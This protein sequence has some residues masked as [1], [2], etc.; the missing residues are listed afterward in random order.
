MGDFEI[1]EGDLWGRIGVLRLR[2]GTLETPALLPVVHPFRQELPPGELKALGFG[3]LMTNAYIIYRRMGTPPPGGVHGLLAF[4]GILA[5]DSGGYQALR[6]GSV[7]V[8]PEDMAS[9]QAALGSDIAVILDTPTRATWGRAKAEESVRL[10]LEAA[11][12][13]ARYLDAGPLWVGAIQGGRHLDLVRA[14]SKALV[15]MGFRMLALGGPVEVMEGYDFVTLLRMMAEARR[16]VPPSIPLHLFGAGLPLTIPLAV[17]LG[18]DTF[19]SASYLL[20]AK[21]GRYMTQQG[22]LRL[23]KVSYLPCAC[24]VC[25]SFSPE[26]LRRDV[27]SLA[28]HN[29]YV[30]ASCIREVKESIHEGRLWEL[31][32]TRARAHPQLWEAAKLLARLSPRF[33]LD[34]PM[35]KPR[36]LFFVAPPDQHRPEVLRYR[37][38]LLRHYTPPSTERLVLVPPPSDR[39]LLRSR[40]LGLC[41]Q[42]GLVPPNATLCTFSP[43]F[44]PIPVELSELY[45]LSQHV[46]S[47]E[48][49]FFRKALALLR[50]FVRLH[51]FKAI[52]VLTDRRSEA[53]MA[54]V[55]RALGVELRPLPKA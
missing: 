19:D 50:A 1:K 23:E 2:R 25:S 32:F 27:L 3:A 15:K 47:R 39:P 26:R 42:L 54:R 34:T 33:E 44:G 10:T 31:V 46:A 49:A 5:T 24:P 28:R 52:T 8:G 37:S 41:A 40:L 30:L 17:A 7:K 13:T 36:A 6:Y 21:Q 20:Y 48:G 38:R 51:G 12:L 29:L 14:C 11:R 55:A 43:P 22:V 9:F 35:T 16:A 45:P 18:F 4:D 53:L